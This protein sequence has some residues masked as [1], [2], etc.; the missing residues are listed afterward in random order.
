MY[1]TYKQTLLTR[2]S[3]LPAFAPVITVFLH[4]LDRIYAAQGLAAAQTAGEQKL[5]EIENTI[6]ALV[7]SR[8]QAQITQ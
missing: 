5:S 8:A 7:Q 1:E 4:T 2:A 6:L 3:K